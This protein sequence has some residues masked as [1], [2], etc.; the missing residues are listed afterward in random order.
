[1]IADLKYYKSHPELFTVKE[2]EEGILASIKYTSMSVDWS[3]ERARM[4]RGIIVELSTGKVIAKPYDKFFNYNQVLSSKELSRRYASWPDNDDFE[5][6][7]KLDGSLGIMYT[8]EGKLK[9]SSSGTVNPDLG[10]D[11][12][13]KELGL[14]SEK[15]LIS[16]NELGKKYT[17][18]FEVLDPEHVI[19]I[20]SPEFSLKLHGIINTD[21]GKDLN[22]DEII[23]LLN[24]YNLSNIPLTPIY[25]NLHTLDQIKDKIALLENKEGFVV[26]F[27]NGFR[28]KFKTK[29]YIA[30]HNSLNMFSS[31][32]RGNIELWLAL[33][34]LGE[35]DDQ[36]SLIKNSPFYNKAILEDIFI[37]FRAIDKFNVDINTAK[38]YVHIYT[39]P[40]ERYDK[41]NLLEYF[42]SDSWGNSL[43]TNVLK[44]DELARENLLY[45][46]V[47]S[48]M[49]N[50]SRKQY[51]SQNRKNL[52]SRLAYLTG[53]K[54]KEE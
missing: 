48:I 44:G 53:S 15:E 4:A 37:F 39:T 24:L 31:A 18:L 34:T 22:R 11:D 7:E 30:F 25:P 9:L 28:L 33:N 20:K 23:S 32:T 40:K 45:S 14:F 5:V 2:D 13:I 6:S 51:T 26:R 17:L 46:Y 12:K 35:L 43:V 1:M 54:I 47:I 29:D 50:T 42:T 52:N 38:R 8:Y 27:S 21:T 16:L 10:W 19:V 36:L 49:T 3:D 41:N